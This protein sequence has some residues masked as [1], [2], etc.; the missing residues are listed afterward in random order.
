MG[1]KVLSSDGRVHRVE[2]LAEALTSVRLILDE[3]DCFWVAHFIGID[4]YGDDIDLI[5]YCRTLREAVQFAAPELVGL[6]L[7]DVTAF[8]LTHTDLVTPTG[9]RVHKINAENW[10]LS[11]SLVQ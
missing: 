9:D 11:N 8:I 7:D 6:G 2:T 1:L 10:Q 4:D 5:R 3:V